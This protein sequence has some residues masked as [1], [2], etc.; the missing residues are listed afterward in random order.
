MIR[1]VSQPQTLLC[2]YFLLLLRK[3]REIG[4]MRVLRRSPPCF[5]L[6]PLFKTSLS[7][8]M[9]LDEMLAVQ[10]GPP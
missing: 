9:Y 8:D 3:E 2:R 10:V 1:D 6:I 5:R 4:G 7:V